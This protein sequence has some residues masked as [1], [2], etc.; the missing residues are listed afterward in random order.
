MLDVTSTRSA[1]VLSVTDQDIAQRKKIPGLES[2]DIAHVVSLKQM[3]EAR[4]D[5]YADIFFDH[6]A[7]IG[8][9]PDPFA[10]RGALD[11]GK[12]RKREHSSGA[13]Q[14][15]RPEAFAWR[16]ARPGCSRRSITC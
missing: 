11:H 15:T 10:R 16:S 1:R 7:K 12:Q 9:A 6:L 5:H 13:G 14:R 3:I 8:A 4:A 2:A